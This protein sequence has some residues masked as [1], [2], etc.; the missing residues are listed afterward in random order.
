[1][2]TSRSPLAT[3]EKPQQRRQLKSDTQ[4][5]KREGHR[6]QQLPPG[7]ARGLCSI[8]SQKIEIRA[9]LYCEL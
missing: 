3:L 4:R 2:K 9:G 8:D 1:M 6:I 7:V 5:W